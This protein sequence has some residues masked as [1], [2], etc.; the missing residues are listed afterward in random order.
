MLPPEQL[1]GPYLK[2]AYDAVVIGP[3]I[4][5]Y[6][7]LQ[8]HDKKTSH[9]LTSKDTPAKD[10]VHNIRATRGHCMYRVSELGSRSMQLL[11]VAMRARV[12]DQSETR[13]FYGN[14]RSCQ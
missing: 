5:D 12:A 8:E 7:V 13:L 3:R 14:D 11:L 10:T 9:A 2:S 1:K 6:C 4:V